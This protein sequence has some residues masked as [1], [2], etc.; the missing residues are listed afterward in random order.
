MGVVAG[1]VVRE[2]WVSHVWG[3]WGIRDDVVGVRLSAYKKMW[4]LTE[5]EVTETVD[6]VGMLGGEEKEEEDGGEDCGDRFRAWRERREKV[7]EG[8]ESINLN[9]SSGVGDSGTI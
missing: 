1:P 2:V 5:V 7:E 4:V 9:H 8:A 6:G 3:G